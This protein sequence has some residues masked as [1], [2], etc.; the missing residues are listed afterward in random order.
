MSVTLDM[1][2]AAHFT[3]MRRFFLSAGAL[4]LAAF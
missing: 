3:S 4:R 1:K 2:K